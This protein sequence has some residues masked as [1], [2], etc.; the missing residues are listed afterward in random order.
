LPWKGLV[1][2]PFTGRDGAGLPPSPQVGTTPASPGWRERRRAQL[3]AKGGGWLRRQ[4][5]LTLAGLVI[6]VMVGAGLGAVGWARVRA[7]TPGRYVDPSQSD[8]PGYVALV[9]PTPTMLVVNEGSDGVL[10]GV[11]LLTLRS[12]DEGGSVIVMPVATRATAGDE[13]VTLAGAY[14][15]GGAE[16]VS[17]AVE[18][19]LNVD[20]GSSIN[21]DDAA[22]SSLVE[23][24]GP[25]SL[26]LEQ[27]VGYWPA[28]AT[29]VSADQAGAFVSAR[30]DDESELG[31]L[32]RQELFWQAWM[33]ALA[34][35]GVDV[36]G[37]DDSGLGRF[38][39]GLANGPLDLAGL[40]VAPEPEALDETYTANEAMVAAL[41]ASEVPY[42]QEPSPGS[43]ARVRLLN[44]TEERDLNLQ[45]IPSLVEAGAEIGL[46]G[47]ADSF[48]EPETRLLY[49]NDDLRDDAERLREALGFGVVE[50][51]PVEQVAPPGEEGQSER[52]D[53]TVIL[54]ADASG[55]IRR[56]E[57]PD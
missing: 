57:S 53:V 21:L 31:R 36:P 38:L 26:E 24:V 51:S 35:G 15:E 45:V 50:A 48:A 11:T 41:V 1:P 17:E 32:S 9:T 13:D 6:L 55:A 28:G 18:S 3:R 52:I 54:G 25:L 43:R 56:S 44:G 20:V 2:P 33:E 46:S 30:R 5:H 42:P 10:A 47:N 23:P 19:V 27:A 49:A 29:Q 8:E 4:Q 37:E 22:L 39:R 16:A 34:D 12:Q 7:S 40:P 14:A